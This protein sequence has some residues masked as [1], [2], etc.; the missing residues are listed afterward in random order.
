MTL[1]GQQ[2]GNYQIKQC[3]GEGAMGSVYLGVHRLIGGR[4]AI[5]VLQRQIA[6]NPEMAERFLREARA[7]SRAEHPGIVKILDY[8]V[9]SEGLPYIAMEYL[10]GQPLSKYIVQRGKLSLAETLRIGQLLAGALASAHARQVVHRDLKPENIM[11]LASEDLNGCTM[12]K[13]VDFGI[14]R[15]ETP[16]DLEK[17][18]RTGAFLGTPCYMSPELILDPRRASDRSDVYALGVILYQML[19]GKQPFRGDS[20]GEVVLK[21]LQEKPPLLRSAGVDV[22]PQLCALI[23]RMLAKSAAE[24]PAMAAVNEALRRIAY[25]S[26]ESARRQTALRTGSRLPSGAARWLAWTVPSLLV[27]AAALGLTHNFHLSRQRIGQVVS[28]PQ[29]RPLSLPAKPEGENADPKKPTPE[30]HPVRP[31]LGDTGPSHKGKSGATTAGHQPDQRPHVRGDSKPTQLK[32]EVLKP[33]PEPIALVMALEPQPLRTL[34]YPFSHEPEPTATGSR[35]N[36]DAELRKTAEKE[37]VDAAHARGLGR[38]RNAIE[39]ARRAVPVLPESAWGFISTLGCESR[40][41]AAAEEAYKHLDP[42]P[43]QGVEETCRAFGV[44]RGRDRWR[45]DPSIHRGGDEQA[46]RMVLEDAEQA[47]L[48]RL[49]DRAIE[50]A[51]L[52][53]KHSYYDAWGII[54]R[55]ACMKADVQLAMTA[56]FR[57]EPLRQRTVRYICHRNGIELPKR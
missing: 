15:I 40:D 14:A 51:Q 56:L 22:P 52:V 53:Q 33:V 35:A 46:T 41:L 57:L 9:T 49:Y 50:H 36:S 38:F 27:G 34:R 28:A 20:L 30:P 4:A 6:R 47:Y 44:V 54:G 12:V 42:L 24:R 18:T 29:E 45:V 43:R 23:R 10:E 5:K 32:T 21:H 37:L 19:A 48:E 1:S 39:L 7:A 17:L 8:G 25:L 11:R 13:I 2:I 31:Q 55:A 16:S 26:D 3:I